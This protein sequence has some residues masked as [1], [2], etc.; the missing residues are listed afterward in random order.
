MAKVLIVSTGDLTALLGR[1]MLWGRDVERVFASTPGAAFEVARAFVPSL[2]VVD[3]ED[4]A[5]AS[6]LV[7]KF[8]DHPGTRRSSIVV[9][10]GAE[11]PRGD[12]LNQGANLVLTGS[13]EPAL[14]DTHFE[15][16]L[17]VP[18]RLRMR[19]PVRLRPGD[20]PA[21]DEAQAEALDLSVAGMLVEAPVPLAPGTLIEL[22][23]AVP[24][25]AREHRAKGVVV[26]SS[27]GG[28]AR[29]GVRFLSLESGAQERI[30]ALLASAPIERT[31]GRYEPLGLLGEGAMGRVYRA[32]DPAAQRVVAIKTLK[33]EHL[34]GSEAEDARRRFCREARAAARLVHPNIITVFDVGDDYFVMELLEGETLQSLL[35]RRGRLDPGELAEILAPVARAL[36]YA[37]GLG[38]IHRDIKPANVM[39]T[40]SGRPKVMD[41]GVAHLA[42][43]SL[44]PSGHFLGSPGYMAPEQLGRGEISGL[45]DV[46][47]LAV[48]AYEALTGHLAFEGDSITQILYQVVHTEP[49]PPSSV[50]PALPAAYD[51]VFRCALAKDPSRRFP[52]AA[53][54]VEALRSAAEASV[55]GAATALDPGAETVDLRGGPPV[56]RRRRLWAAAALSV[57]VAV[58]SVL[59]LPRPRP[60]VV[61]VVTPPPGLMIASEPAEA[62][63]WLDGRP[64]GNSPLF[65]PDLPPGEHTVRVEREGYAPAQLSL[66]TPGEGPPLPLHF[67]LQARRGRLS[68]ESEPASATVRVDGRPVGRTPLAELSLPA[69]ARRV[70]IEHPG[71]SAWARTVEVKPGDTQRVLARL[72]R[73]PVRGRSPEALRRSGW[74]LAGDLVELGPGVTPPRKVAGGAAAYPE[75]ARRLRVAGT[76]TVEL[77]VTETGEVADVRVV[78]SAGELLDR[79]LLES[80]KTWRYEP[81]ERS[82]VKVSVRIREQQAF[83][84]P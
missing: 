4:P 45:A 30:E 18:H 3:G 11:A 68:I 80:V 66:K 24:G 76:V 69:G 38:T 2:V 74:V 44:T 48:V 65:L 54:F 71:R 34:T 20:A 41:F 9:V 17:L 70:E 62:A 50:N 12:A 82:R 40:T 42:S 1:T 60:A 28:P 27:G 15:K 23:F 6:T 21:E 5:A 32:F 67:T 58:A 57:G 83:V 8:R 39:I 16:L 51:P 29:L 37:H 53:A 63:V 75:E 73:G 33:P 19:I 46:F 79:A 78:E 84:A 10:S 52:T 43:G 59:L 55:P 14:W 56:G 49:P 77:T 31:F 64:V 26:R 22:R 72:E 36:D 47:S 13:V 61:D 35:R 81:A 25:A 7:R